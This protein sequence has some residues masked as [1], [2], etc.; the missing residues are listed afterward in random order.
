[1]KSLADLSREAGGIEFAFEDESRPAV[2][3]HVPAGE[4]AEEF[5]ENEN[6]FMEFFRRLGE[7]V[8]EADVEEQNER[9]KD[10]EVE[11]ESTLE[12][13]KRRQ[14]RSFDE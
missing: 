5:R 8:L 14:R 12:A 1:M 7:I 11:G 9:Y 13:I 2:R 4:Q 3:V 6:H 10:E